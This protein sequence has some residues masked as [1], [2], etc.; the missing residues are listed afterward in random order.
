M[1]EVENIEPMVFIYEND[2]G[3]IHREEYVR[4]GGM[5]FLIRTECFHKTSR[6]ALDIM[7]ERDWLCGE[8]QYE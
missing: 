3:W 8:G 5:N 1:D 2:H 7:D 6:Q 4:F